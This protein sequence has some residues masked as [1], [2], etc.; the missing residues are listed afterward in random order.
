MKISVK[1]VGGNWHFA[2]AVYLL[3]Q[4]ENAIVFDIVLDYP[5]CVNHYG[6]SG[7]GRTFSVFLTDEK[8]ALEEVRFEINE[9]W[10]CIFSEIQKGHCLV[11]IFKKIH[12]DG[13]PELIWEREE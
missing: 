2:G 10:G 13:P 9:E 7:D 11:A 1:T 3:Q 5:C 8:K 4:S 12:L 6:N